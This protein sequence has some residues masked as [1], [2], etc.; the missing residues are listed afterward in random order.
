MILPDAKDLRP[1]RLVSMDSNARGRTRMPD[2]AC[3]D[4]WSC[5]IHM[6]AEQLNVSACLHEYEGRNFSKKH[7]IKGRPLF[8]VKAYIDSRSRKSRR[9]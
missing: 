7:Y 5:D 6:L 4:N 2:G 1:I 9:A 8:L 3:G